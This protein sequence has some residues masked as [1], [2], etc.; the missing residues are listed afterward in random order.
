MRKSLLLIG[1]LV[2]LG[3]V[4]TVLAQTTV[5][6]LDLDAINKAAQVHARNLGQFVDE[7]LGHQAKANA[8]QADELEDLVATSRAKMQAV[9]AAKAKANP[10]G[11]Q[12]DLD[13]LVADA[14]RSMAPSAQSASQSTPMLI[15]FASLSMPPE[16]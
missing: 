3:G 6:G 16:S 1:S 8:D 9:A 7:V 12:V 13:A 5:D 4:G 2:A 10:T 14:G 15:A 11:D